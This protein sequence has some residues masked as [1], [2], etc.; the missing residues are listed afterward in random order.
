M[1]VGR[2]VGSFV[3]SFVHAHCQIYERGE[4]SQDLAICW[5]L[6][7]A[8]IVRMRPNWKKVSGLEIASSRRLESFDLARVTD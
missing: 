2:S 8:I 3:R 4:K 5:N 6:L 7:F 1:M